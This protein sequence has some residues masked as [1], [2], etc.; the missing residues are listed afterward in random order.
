MAFV[1]FL[2]M[3]LCPLSFLSY[4]HLSSPHLLLPAYLPTS[5]FLSL[6]LPLLFL[7]FSYI[8]LA[9][10][11]SKI[12][13]TIL[14]EDG[15][16]AQSSA[17]DRDSTPGGSSS[18][19]REESGALMA[20]IDAFFLPNRLYSVIT[21]RSIGGFELILLHNPWHSIAE[22]WTGKLGECHS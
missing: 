16:T 22:C 20:P 6:S 13:I 2:V 14:D 11:Y 10:S 8:S 3:C 15:S 18:P 9:Y 1:T 21:T 7:H 4:I 19:S 17:K 12:E 5:P